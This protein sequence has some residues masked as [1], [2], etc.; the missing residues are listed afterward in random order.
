[1]FALV[2]CLVIVVLDQATKQWVRYAFDL[3]ESREVIQG[4]FSLTYV[5]NTGAAWGMLRGQNTSL[6]LLSVVMLILMV[7]FRRSFLND[8]WSHR[9]ALGLMLGGI[10]GNLLDRLRLRF[11]TDFLDFYWQGWHCPALNVADAAICTG[12]GIYLITSFRSV[13]QE[14]GRSE[15]LAGTDQTPAVRD[16]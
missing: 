2:T 9:L 15:A 11:V 14:Q 7:V 10:L 13:P 16:R 5:Q 3:H 12:V 8:T 4:F 6:T 1:M